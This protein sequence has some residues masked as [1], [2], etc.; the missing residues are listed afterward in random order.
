M[1]DRLVV[2]PAR[3]T[4]VLEPLYDCAGGFSVF[5]CVTDENV[6]GHGMLYPL[7][8][9]RRTSFTRFG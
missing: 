3:D 2:D 4:D 5:S 1:G 9:R 7:P 8:E 6:V